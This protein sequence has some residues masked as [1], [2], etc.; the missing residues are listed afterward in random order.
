MDAFNLYNRTQIKSVQSIIQRAFDQIL[1]VE[2]AIS[3]KHFSL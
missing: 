1:G 2:G 3:I